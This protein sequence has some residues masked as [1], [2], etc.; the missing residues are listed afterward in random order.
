MTVRVDEGVLRRIGRL[1][2]VVQQPPG[3]A[4]AGGLVVLD[5]LGEGRPVSCSRPS[6][7]CRLIGKRRGPFVPG[8]LG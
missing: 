4:V 1:V 7:D 2:G 5:Q 8:L 3:Q 6:N